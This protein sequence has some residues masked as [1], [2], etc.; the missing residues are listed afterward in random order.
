MIQHTD[1]HH[2]IVDLN[3][4]RLLRDAAWCQARTAN[5]R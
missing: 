3:G 2:P 5:G 4:L 1:R